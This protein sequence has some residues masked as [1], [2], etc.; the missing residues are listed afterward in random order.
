M[1]FD[2]PY[3]ERIIKARTLKECFTIDEDRSFSLRLV[4]TAVANHVYGAKVCFRLYQR[5]LWKRMKSNESPNPS[6]ILNR[7]LFI[8]FHL[9][10]SPVA[11][12]EPGILGLWYGWQVTAGSKICRGAKLEKGVSLVPS[13][14]GTPT[15]LSGACLHTYCVIMGAV[16]IGKNSIIGANSVVIT[17]VEENTTVMG[18]PARKVFTNA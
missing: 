11:E 4:F 15:V 8:I 12:L 3:M 14:N 9:E 17:D 5:N 16:I 2:L 1:N 10:I 13:K 18:N 6:R 7:I